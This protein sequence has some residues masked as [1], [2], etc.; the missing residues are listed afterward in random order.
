MTDI[1]EVIGH[2]QECQDGTSAPQ[3]NNRSHHQSG[4][5]T[6]IAQLTL[7]KKGLQRHFVCNDCPH[8][9]DQT[10]CGARELAVDNMPKDVWNLDAR[11][12]ARMY[13]QLYIGD[14]IIDSLFFI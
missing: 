11:T 10:L 7:L 1:K 14:C 9:R 13:C 4:A 6:W 2:S 12:R 8:I 5:S 3:S